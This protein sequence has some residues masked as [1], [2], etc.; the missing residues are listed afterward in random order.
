[1]AEWPD[2]EQVAQRLIAEGAAS[3]TALGHR[4]VQWLLIGRVWRSRC[5]DCAR[6]AI[7]RPRVWGAA[8]IGGEALLL[9]C[10]GRA[11]SAQ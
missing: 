11:Q 7:V 4:L 5:A 10:T 8:P 6:P 3:A 1:M 9:R 2:T